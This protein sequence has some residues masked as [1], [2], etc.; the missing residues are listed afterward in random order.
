MLMKWGRIG[1][2]QP[3]KQPNGLMRE[4][5][6]SKD[7]VRPPHRLP[8]P[9]LYC[10]RSLYFFSGVGWHSKLNGLLQLRRAT[11]ESF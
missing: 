6:V 5:E 7:E 1:E 2:L 3:E 9:L 4:L 11:D 8:F 10:R